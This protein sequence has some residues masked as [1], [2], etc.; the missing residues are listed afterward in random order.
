MTS[1][2]IRTEAMDPSVRPCDDFWRYANGKWL[3]DTAIPADEAVWGGFSELRDRNLAI[4]REILESASAGGHEPGSPRQ[5]VGDLY[6]SGMDEPAIERAG[7]GPVRGLLDDAAAVTATTLP[8]FLGTL[9]RLGVPAAFLPSIQPDAFDSGRA[10]VHLFQAGLG[11][12]DRDHYLRD[13]PRSVTLRRQYRAHVA[14]MFCLLGESADHAA[15]LADDVE[16]FERLLAEAAMPRAEQR[17]PYKVNNLRTRA[18][19]AAGAP[20]FDWDGFLAAFGASEVIDLNVRQPAF[21]ATVAELARDTPITT[22][23]T[24]LRWH[25]ARAFAPYLPDAFGAAAFAFYGT[26]L[27]GQPERKPRWKRVLETVDGQLGQPLGMLYVE[28]TF[29]P[30]AKRRILDLVA[31]LRAVLGE[32]IDTLEWMSTE[33]RVAARR[34]LD[35]FAVKMGYPDTWRDYR[36]LRIERDDH[37]GNVIR[38]TLFET[39][40]GLGKLAR[41]VDRGEWKMSPPTVNAYYYPPA[42]EIVFP[43]GILQPPFFYPDGDAAV[44]YGAIGMVIGHEMTHGF[45]DQGSQ[46][47]EVGNL[48]NWWQP[49][50]EA[51]YAARADLVVQQYE[52]FRPLP[53]MRINGRLCLGENIADIGGVRI[54]YAALERHLAAHGEPAPIDGFTARQRFFIGLAQSWRSLVREETLRVR[55]TID[56][57]SPSEFRVLGSLADMPEF[58]A[59]FGGDGGAML[60]PAAERPTIW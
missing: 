12:P 52:A 4:L 32:R 42:N 10:I 2:P 40:H 54:A 31:D 49:A 41:P 48:R 14:T 13:D 15:S 29:P 20:G 30:E 19:L 43:A 47:D 50:D 18:A 55:L 23:R 1:R 7:L 21:I 58:Y 39:A 38:A 59:A 28:R 11:L 6:A 56:P 57:H 36:G 44:N 16:A 8:G 35:A 22:W 37:L 5:Q 60:R 53:D 45:D 27:A 9:H 26:V 3:R 24:Y 34:K 33:T 51:A 46:F 25:I 17:D